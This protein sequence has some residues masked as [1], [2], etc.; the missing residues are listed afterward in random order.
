MSLDLKIV[1]CCD[2]LGNRESMGPSAGFL[3]GAV[4][5]YSLGKL[6]ML[7]V[8]TTRVDGLPDG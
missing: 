1:H 7:V 2:C 8:E 3:S 6:P 4:P 5:S